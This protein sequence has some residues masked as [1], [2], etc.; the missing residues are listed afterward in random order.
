MVTRRAAKWMLGSNSLVLS[1]IAEWLVLANLAQADF[2]ALVADM[3][4]EFDHFMDGEGFQ[5]PEEAIRVVGKA[6]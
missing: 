4:G 2:D 6:I 1:N 5:L 3:E